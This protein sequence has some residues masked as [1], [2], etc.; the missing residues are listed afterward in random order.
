[1][2]LVCTI[3]EKKISLFISTLRL[4]F[5]CFIEDSNLKETLMTFCSRIWIDPAKKLND[6]CLH[7]AEWTFC[8]IIKAAD[9]LRSLQMDV[10]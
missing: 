4:E 2:T 7:S 10:Y 3:H 5:F 6:I 9:L 8:A 1:M